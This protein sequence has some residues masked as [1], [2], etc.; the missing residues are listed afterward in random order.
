MAAGLLRSGVDIP[1]ESARIR[2][3]RPRTPRK[4]TVNFMRPSWNLIPLDTLGVLRVRG[5]DVRAFLQGQLSNDI[6]APERAARA[7]GRL[8]Q[9]AGTRDRAAAPRAARRRT[10]CSPCCRASCVAPVAARLG[11]FVLRAK[12]RLQDESAQWQSSTGSRSAS[13]APDVEAQAQRCPAL[14]DDGAARGLITRIVRCSHAPRAL[15]ADPP[16]QAHPRRS[17]DWRPLAAR[18]LAAGAPSPP[19]S[20]RSTRRPRRS[21]S[22]RC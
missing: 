1:I 13:A 9:R 4:T 10:M 17:Q 22:R 20:R 16:A 11:K 15:A 3:Q 12:V 21:S 6:D 2:A 8:P 7:A 19:A 14:R 5:A 18:G